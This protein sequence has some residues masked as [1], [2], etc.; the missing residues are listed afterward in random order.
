M[1]R[2]TNK[3]VRLH[4]KVMDKL[5]QGR[6]TIAQFYKTPTKKHSE[7]RPIYKTPNYPIYNKQK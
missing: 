4:Y 3:E 7:N 2:K 1:D 6:K 5:H